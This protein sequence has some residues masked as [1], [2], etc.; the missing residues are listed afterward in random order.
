M[1]I[2]F[3]GLLS[4]YSLFTFDV[5]QPALPA[6]AD[7]FSTTHDVTQLTL[8]IYLFFFGVSQL[9]WGP[10]IDHF[11]RKK[12]L[13]KSLLIAVIASFVGMLAPNITIV[14]IA[15]AIQG[16]AICCSGMIAQAASRDYDDDK[17]R[18]KVIS[19]VSMVVSASPII[20][21]SVGAFLL[22]AFS[23]R[24]SFLLMSFWGLALIGFCWVYLSESKFW[25]PASTPFSI[26]N[27]LTNYHKI[28]C[29]RYLMLGASIIAMA[30]SAVMITIVNA[31]Y[32]I[33]NV[34]GFSVMSFAIIFMFNGLNIIFSNYVGIRLR[35]IF[36]MNQN[37]VLGLIVMVLG[38]VLMELVMAF[39]GFSLT[40]LALALIVNLGV[41]IV[42][43][44][45][46][47]L[48]LGHYDTLTGSAV[49]MM[50][51]MR[52]GIS[53]IVS[54]AVSALIDDSIH[55]L[56]F[57]LIGCA[58]LGLILSYPFIKDKSHSAGA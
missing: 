44:P 57:S 29:H 11:G 9:V 6:I 4:A 27:T 30:F 50:N 28:I 43:P 24:A 49:A 7:A 31:A 10:L 36:T 35:E 13:V 40:V 37:I 45:V 58:V 48:V 15:R 32:L 33:I 17:I 56:T 46:M 42:I 22:Q 1:P 38:G 12:L 55:Y 26:R 23:W 41:G 18:A 5:Y 8:N 19:F 53:A 39:Q 25:K 54:I 14:I 16:V 51:A 2:W 34:L 47:S 21:P 3:L 52:V 20:A